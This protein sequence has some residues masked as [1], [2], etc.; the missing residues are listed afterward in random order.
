METSATA[1]IPL[2]IQVAGG[3]VVFSW[4]NP[5]FVLQAAPS[6]TGTYSNVAGATSPYTNNLTGSQMV[7][8][9]QAG[10]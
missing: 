9:L 1:P 8:R 5:I 10:N 7:F 4:S 3:K 6:M 2:N